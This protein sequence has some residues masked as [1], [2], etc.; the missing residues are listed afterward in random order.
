MEHLLPELKQLVHLGVVLP[1]DKE[2]KQK[3][4]CSSQHGKTPAFRPPFDVSYKEL[5]HAATGHAGDRGPEVQLIL[6]YLDFLAAVCSGA[7]RIPWIDSS[8]AD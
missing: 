7:R 5:F 8:S 3:C 2:L 4:L 1:N 6:C